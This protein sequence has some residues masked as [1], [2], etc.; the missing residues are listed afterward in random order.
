MLSRPF[1]NRLLCLFLLSIGLGCPLGVDADEKELSMS[2]F[3]SIGASYS[4]GNNFL[5][6]DKQQ[7]ELLNLG[8]N[9]NYNL[10]SNFS[11]KAQV[12][13]RRAGETLNDNGL[14]LDFAFV[15]W[16]S[17]NLGFGEQMIAIGRVKSPAGLYNLTRDIPSSRPNIYL[18]QSIYLDI[19]R[20]L[21]L[22]IDGIKLRS[23][24]D[25]SS[26]LLSV[27]AIVGERSLDTN[28]GF[29]AFA[30]ERAN[31]APSGKWSSDTS[32]LLD[33]K[34]STFNTTIGFTYSIINTN[35]RANQARDLNDIVSPGSSLF[36]GKLISETLI[37][38]LQHY[39]NGFEFT[40][41]FNRRNF[42]IKGII[43]NFP[44]KKRPSQGYY[45]QLRYGFD[46]AVT[47]MA[48]YDRLYRNADDKNGTLAPSYG[49]PSWAEKAQDYTFA[50]NWVI[51]ENVS[52]NSEIHFVEGSAW[53]PPFALLQPNAFEEKH[54][55]LFSTE[56]VYKF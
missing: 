18:P 55:A 43:A 10:P 30:L 39:V 11:A 5:G 52:L 34:Y 14:Q 54:W 50:L 4:S 2:G 46:N 38:S 17:N 44:L 42:E 51:N 56:L 19:F 40:S 53:L 12:A 32:R 28:F 21:T 15:D 31:Q 23:V 41:E 48:R 37:F 24:H 33:I 6:D 8:I 20:N 26:G 45:L 9:A 47:V 22:N 27:E 3:A 1:N 36:D 13:Y 29:N 35:F 25:F 49:V 7:H 16:S